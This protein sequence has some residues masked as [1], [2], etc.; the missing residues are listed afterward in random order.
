[1]HG[2]DCCSGISSLKH[3]HRCIRCR[4]KESGIAPALPRGDSYA[5]GDS[6]NPW[7]PTEDDLK[8]ATKYKRKVMGLLQ[9]ASADS[10]NMEPSTGSL[11]IDYSSDSVQHSS[12]SRN[13]SKRGRTSPSCL[14]AGEVGTN[15]ISGACSSLRLAAPQVRG[16]A[17]PNSRRPMR[18]LQSRLLPCSRS[19]SSAATARTLRY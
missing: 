6:C 14:I 2:H 9:Q 13:N 4:M 1:M 10:A 5:L 16:S 18:L 12:S 8:L 11:G 15:G 19:S 7:P 17:A 3:T